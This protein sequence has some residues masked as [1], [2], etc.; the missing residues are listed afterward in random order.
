MMKNLK[1]ELIMEIK[2]ILDKGMQEKKYY[3][4]KKMLDKVMK[5]KKW[6]LFEKRHDERKNSE[7]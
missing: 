2:K 6:C 4:R 5:E 3:S 1:L 7:N